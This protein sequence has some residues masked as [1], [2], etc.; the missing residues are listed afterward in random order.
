MRGERGRGRER[1]RE[2]EVFW[3]LRNNSATVQWKD[4]GCFWFADSI[5]L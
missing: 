1:Q 5:S 4:L 3:R 2:R